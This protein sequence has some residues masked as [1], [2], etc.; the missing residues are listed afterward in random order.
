MENNF[1]TNLIYLRESRNEKQ[2]ETATA[3]GLSRSTYANYEAG[4]NLPKADVLMK[5]LGHF[6]V[7]FENIM[8]ENLQD[9]HLNKKTG[10]E[11]LQANAHLNAHRSAHPNQEKQG[12]LPIMEEPEA[13]YNTAQTSPVQ[14]QVK[15]VIRPV[16]VTVDHVGREPLQWSM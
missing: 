10:G 9:A 4:D 14:Y 15:E 1:S 8:S 11:N 2:A 12:S 5:I 3:L 7:S 6:G 16:M 13:P